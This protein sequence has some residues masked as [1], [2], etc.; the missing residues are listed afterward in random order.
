MRRR[1]LLLLVQ[2]GYTALEAVRI[3]GVLL[4]DPY[5]GRLLKGEP[6]QLGAGGM[7][8]QQLEEGVLY[9]VPHA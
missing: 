7:W 4:G 5:L 6:P 2:N 9:F 3:V 1:L 8:L